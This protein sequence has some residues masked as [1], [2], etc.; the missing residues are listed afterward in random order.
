M[1]DGKTR[2]GLRLEKQ[3]AN[4][5]T[6]CVNTG[7]SKRQTA[8][9]DDALVSIVVPVYNTKPYLNRCIDSLLNQTHRALE[10]LL[11]DDGSTDGSAALLDAYTDPRVRVVH[12]KNGGV[13]A[14]RNTGIV[15]A[16]GAYIGFVDSD[17]WVEPMYVERLLRPFGESADLDISICGWYVH[18]DGRVLPGTQLGLGRIDGDAAVRA[19]LDHSR[20]FHGYLWNKL[21]RS[22]LP[23]HIDED[24]SV[25][26]DLLL[27]VKLLHGG[28]AAYDSGEPLYHY[29]YRESGALRTIDEKRM[30]EFTARERIAALLQSNAP[31]Y[32]AAALA[33]V[34]AALNLLAEAKET[35]NEPLRQAMQT[36]I[37]ARLPMLLHAKDLSRKER[38]KLRIRR[39]FPKTSLR[40]FRRLRRDGGVYEANL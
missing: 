3:P 10:L 20:G 11:I 13:G 2:I 7:V 23:L 32:R 14:A 34:K 5:Y 40:I 28:A 30:S 26:E 16:L 15:L 1:I 12:Q 21:F 24:V 37:D 22:S 9:T 36:R 6:D 4:C 33:E 25:C 8:C 35:G 17:D 27:C 38:I 31:L 19:A 29:R 18:R 39:A